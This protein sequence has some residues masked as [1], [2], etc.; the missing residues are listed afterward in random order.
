MVSFLYVQ[1]EVFLILE[2]SQNG[3]LM[4]Y[5][6]RKLELLHADCLLA[7]LLLPFLRASPRVRAKSITQWCAVHQGWE[8]K[9]VSIKAKRSMDTFASAGAKNSRMSKFGLLSI[10]MSQ[11]LRHHIAKT[12]LNEAYVLLKFPVASRGP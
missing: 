1:V 12:L 5:E 8:E 4:L 2:L 3:K 10:Y 11:L 7:T 6:I 9:R